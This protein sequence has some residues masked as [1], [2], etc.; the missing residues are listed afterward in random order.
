MSTQQAFGAS[1]PPQF[2]IRRR[3]TAVLMSM[4]YITDMR[5]QSGP[6]KLARRP[7]CRKSPSPSST[8]QRRRR[9]ARCQ[10]LHATR[11]RAVRLTPERRRGVPMRGRRHAGRVGCQHGRSAR[12]QARGRG[13]PREPAPRRMRRGSVWASLAVRAGARP[14]SVRPHCPPLG[15]WH[16]RGACRSVGRSAAPDARAQPS[17]TR[18]LPLHSSSAITSQSTG[19][20]TAGLGCG[21]GVICVGSRLS[22]RWACSFVL[23]LVVA[24]GV[25]RCTTMFLSSASC[26]HWSQASARRMFASV[27]AGSM[28]RLYRWQK[29]G[30]RSAWLAS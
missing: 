1:G 25:V 9:R 27:A 13:H 17:S 3:L 7:P 12:R 4:S 5:G 11:L 20:P 21:R 22:R 10:R 24:V 28:R 8:L 14:G 18:S 15:R 23:P 29:V 2:Y 30:T 6:R 19:E 16:V 26:T